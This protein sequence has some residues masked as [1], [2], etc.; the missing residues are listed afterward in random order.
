MLRLSFASVI[1][2]ASFT[3]VAGAPAAANAANAAS[4]SMRADASLR[5]TRDA[6]ADLTFVGD[7]EPEGPIGTPEDR[8]AARD[9]GRELTEP[10]PDARHWY[11]WE[12]LTVD[13]VSIA[14]MPLAGVGV[15]GYLLGAPI[16]HAAHDR[17]GA[18]ATSLGMRVALPI[19]GA[20]AGVALA[21][22]PK[23][24]QDEGMCGLGEALVGLGLGMLT[25]IVIDAAVLGY[26]PA[27]SKS[28]TIARLPQVAIAPWIER[29]RKG[30]SLA[31]TF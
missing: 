9:I 22:C 11:G 19:A 13:A 5:A 1:A 30:A 26:E 24:T 18:A 7:A 10:D 29:D 4:G 2:L 16:V 23:N 6:H 25:A 20:Y 14:A 3:L 17:W 21:N 15:G 12:T 28:A 31:L 27:P 8:V